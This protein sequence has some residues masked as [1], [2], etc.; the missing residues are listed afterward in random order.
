[1]PARLEMFIS[2][3]IHKGPR[4]GALPAQGHCLR[5]NS[6]PKGNVCA[7]ALPAHEWAPKYGPPSL[8]GPAAIII[9]ACK[10]GTRLV[11]MLW[12]GLTGSVFLLGY[13]C[14][15]HSIA[16]FFAGQL[17]HRLWVGFTGPFLLGI[18]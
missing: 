9:G 13:G 16:L 8:Q 10:M 1:M 4:Q 5:M 12:T 6:L 18:G 15:W 3:H 7:R 2:L 11:L 17:S 14:G